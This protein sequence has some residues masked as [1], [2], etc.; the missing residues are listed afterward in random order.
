M[1]DLP[2]NAKRPFWFTFVTYLAFIVSALTWRMP[3][4]FAR[5]GRQPRLA[6]LVTPT[7]AQDELLVQAVQIATSNVFGAIEERPLPDGSHKLVLN[8]GWRNFR[9]P[10]ARDFG[11][12]SFGLVELNQ[13]RAL[14][15]TLE[16]FLLFQT[17]EGQFPIKVHSTNVLERF[18]Y[19]HF[20]RQQPIHTPLRPKYMTAHNTISL[21]GNA[22][23]IIAA[24]NY[25]RQVEDDTFC[26][27]HWQALKRGLQWLE[28]RALGSRGLLHQGVYTDWADSVRRTG[29]VHYTNMLYWK[30]LH[31]FAIDAAHYSYTDDYARFSAQ[32]EQIKAAINA[33]FWNEEGGFY[34]TSRLFP[35]ILS[36]AGNL[37]AIAWGLALPEQAALILD[38]MDAL[39][40]AYPVPTQV[41][42]QP[43][44]SAFIAIEN[45]LAGIPH[46][47]TAAAWIWLG[48]W[49]VAALVRSGRLAEAYELLERMSAVIVRDG[50]VHEVY[51][52][53]GHHLSTRWYTSEAPLT[54][55]ASMF[56]YA[57]AMYQRAARGHL[58]A[59]R[60]TS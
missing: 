57:E 6:S 20:Q 33:H 28:T 54:W 27:T 34:S 2:A 55:S 41:T 49:H 44:G 45:R 48:A 35:T 26:R 31:E 9:E 56:V 39:G 23:L 30:A 60:T 43:Y 36:S 19:S 13:Q 14:R 53:H 50:V 11:F 16:L 37:L 40:M 10:W 42:S 59:T 47:H 25:L 15:E 12:A 29:M 5:L 52:K 8:A 58:D 21:D 32:A 38:K 17:S 22:L 1:D 24:L 51:G 4:F 7:D 46:Y 18:L 3:R